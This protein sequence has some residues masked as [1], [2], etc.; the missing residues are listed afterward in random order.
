M[1]GVSVHFLGTGDAFG[2]GGRLQTSTLLRSE[3]GQVLV[4]C[5]ASTLAA[6]RAQRLDPSAID[7]IALTHLHGDHFSRPAVLP[8]GRALRGWAH[9]PADDRRAGRHRPRRRPRPRRVLPRHRCAAAAVP[10]DV[11]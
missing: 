9:P 11:G 7:T 8:D 3:A 6:L 4:D 1:T 10:A 2:S 5:G